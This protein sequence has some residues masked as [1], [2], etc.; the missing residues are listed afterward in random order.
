MKPYQVGHILGSE[1]RLTA[2]IS[3]EV[4]A[5]GF[6][7]AAKTLS[8]GEQD[9]IAQTLHGYERKHDL[10]RREYERKSTILLSVASVVG[11]PAA[12]AGFTVPLA[13]GLQHPL[14]PAVAFLAFA[15]GILACIVGFRGYYRFSSLSGDSARKAENFRDARRELKS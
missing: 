15:A 2:V 10:L 9:V 6:I 7:R 1:Q 14:A 4:A 12:F 3:D 5:A 11:G 8:K 13:A